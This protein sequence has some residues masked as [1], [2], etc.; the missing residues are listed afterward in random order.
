MQLTAI[1]TLL[2]AAKLR[3]R[4][5]SQDKLDGDITQLVEF[6]LCDLERIGVNKTHLE[7]PDAMI[8]EAVLVYVKAN[9]GKSPDTELMNSY[10]MILTKIKGCRKYGNCSKADS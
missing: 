7:N 9:Y 1:E 10:N 8:K 3:V 4:K 2:K 6:V 5:S